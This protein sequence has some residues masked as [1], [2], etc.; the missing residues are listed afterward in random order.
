MNEFKPKMA[1][2]NLHIMCALL[3]KDWRLFRLP[4]FALVTIVV[5]CYS[6]AAASERFLGYH[7]LAFGATV[8]AATLSGVLASAF[9]GLAIAGERA[10]RTMDFLGVLPITR[11]QII[12]SKWTISFLVLGLCALLQYFIATVLMRVVVSPL[13]GTG[14]SSG[15]LPQVIPEWV[16]FSASFFGIAW[17]LGTFLRTPA[18]SACA[19]IA[20]TLAWFAIIETRQHANHMEHH[21]RASLILTSVSLAI[22]LTS[23][24]GGTLYYLRRVEP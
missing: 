3:A 20:A 21:P 15:P 5:G 18:I 11:G 22:G 7:S 10:D 8:L 14:W 1:G 19:S 6:P 9:G 24:I 23:L 4:T 2:S 16:A 17:L 12:F 13:D